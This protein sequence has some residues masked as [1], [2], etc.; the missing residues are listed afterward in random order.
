M[1]LKKRGNLGK[2]SHLENGGSS[3][4]RFELCSQMNPSEKRHFLKSNNVLGEKRKDWLFR[5]TRARSKACIGNLRERVEDTLNSL[6]EAEV[7]SLP[8]KSS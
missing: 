8:S 6:L 3:A 1:L 5:S 4:N 7:Q 2:V